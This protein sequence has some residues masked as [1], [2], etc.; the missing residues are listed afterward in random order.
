MWL[1]DPLIQHLAAL[2][3]VYQS[4]DMRSGGEVERK[5][6]KEFSLKGGVGGGEGVCACT[7]IYLFTR[8]IHYVQAYLLEDLLHHLLTACWIFP[9]QQL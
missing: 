6:V 2:H 9:L 1:R 5:C 8:L 4:G 3:D 7:C